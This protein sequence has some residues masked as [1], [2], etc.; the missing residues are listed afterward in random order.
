MSAINRAYS[1]S[2]YMEIAHSGFI[3]IRVI[4]SL[5]HIMCEP[6]FLLIALQIGANSRGIRPLSGLQSNR[7]SSERLPTVGFETE[8]VTAAEDL[9]V[10]GLIRVQIECM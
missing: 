5:I 6:T 4:K 9:T 3:N 8:R 10:L 7:T 1:I 2:S